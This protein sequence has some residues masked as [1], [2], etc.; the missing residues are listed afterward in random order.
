M[1]SITTCLSSILS[2]NSLSLSLDDSIAAKSQ[3]K[4]VPY[5]HWFGSSL[6][7][8]I[9][10]RLFSFFRSLFFSFLL[11]NQS[12]TTIVGLKRCSEWL[13][14]WSGANLRLSVRNFRSKNSNNL[15]LLSNW[16]VLICAINFFS[17]VIP[18]A[19]NFTFQKLILPRVALFDSKRE[20]KLPQTSVLS[21]KSESKRQIK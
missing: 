7:N 14:L 8:W 19:Q 4:S 16:I 6:S 12:K 5:L 2:T 13:I 9:S 20:K 18:Y 21:F 3:A 15:E 11:S 17:R 1:A 10:S